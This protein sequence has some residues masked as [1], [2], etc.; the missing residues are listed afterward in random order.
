MR[1]KALGL[2]VVVL[3]LLADDPTGEV[4]LSESEI[5]RR[6]GVSRQTWLDVAKF[7]ESVGLIERIGRFVNSEPGQWA[8]WK[9]TEFEKW[10]GRITPQAPPDGETLSAVV[11][12][13]DPVPVSAARDEPVASVDRQTLDVQQVSELDRQDR[14]DGQD[15]YYKTPPNPPPTESG[16]VDEELELFPFTDRSLALLDS[17]HRDE[18]WQ[19][20]SVEWLRGRA[21]ASGA[22]T[23]ALERALVDARYDLDDGKVPRNP[24]GWIVAVL[25]RYIGE[26][27]PAG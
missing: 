21:V 7:L 9:I 19:V 2:F 11:S 8:G 25:R 24:R 27:V 6:L 3:V 4:T 17:L 16:G 1:V 26:Q 18:R 15:N 12:Q 22:T 14:Q 10:T 5:A 23:T 20:V 13:A